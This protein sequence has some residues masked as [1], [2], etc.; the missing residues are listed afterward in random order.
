LGV[1][2]S[3]EIYYKLKGPLPAGPYH[4]TAGGYQPA[5]DAKVHV[6]LIWRP[7]GLGGDQTI[8][9][10]DSVAPGSDAGLAGSID[11]M[12]DG[13]AVPAKCG[14]WLVMS[15]KMVS[16]S[17]DFIEFGVSLKIP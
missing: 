2:H 1:G 4:V 5:N 8:T 16:G 7:A 17:N 12:V 11:A 6:D 15:V 14:D 10:A 9:S 13:A 3:Q